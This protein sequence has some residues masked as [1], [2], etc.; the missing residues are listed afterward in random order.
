MFDIPAFA[1]TKCAMP[2]SGD[3]IVTRDYRD[4]ASYSQSFHQK[5]RD[6]NHC[7]V[8]VDGHHVQVKASHHRVLKGSPVCWW[9]LL[10]RGAMSKH[11]LWKSSSYAK[12]HVMID[13]GRLKYRDGSSC[14]SCDFPMRIPRSIMTLSHDREYPS[15]PIC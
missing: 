2:L 8:V 3:T 5:I 15:C 11:L 13:G 9:G 1:F 14:L 10:T 12:K 7:G 4:E 6:I